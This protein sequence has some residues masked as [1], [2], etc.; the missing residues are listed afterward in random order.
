[1]TFAQPLIIIALATPT[2]EP[3]SDAI[4]SHSNDVLGGLGAAWAIACWAI[5]AWLYSKSRL[6][7][8]LSAAAQFT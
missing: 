2:G 6:S 4:G 7:I 3:N 5:A 1:M 8:I